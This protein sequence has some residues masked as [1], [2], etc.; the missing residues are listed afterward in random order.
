MTSRIQKFADGA[1]SSQNPGN[2]L[3]P[4]RT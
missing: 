2:V 1:N 3:T 4:R